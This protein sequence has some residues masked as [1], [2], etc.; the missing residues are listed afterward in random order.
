MECP[1]T[2]HAPERPVPEAG[3]AGAD[4]APTGGQGATRFRRGLSIA[5]VVGVVLVLVTGILWL[6][7]ATSGSTRLAQD[8]DAV[9]VAARQAGETV[10][11]VDKSDAAGTVARWEAV[12]TGS[13]LDEL[14]TSHDQYVQ[15]IGKLPA[16]A[17]GTVT[18]AAVAE[19][20]DRAGTARVLVG[21]DVTLDDGGKTPP[22]RQRVQME[23]TRTDDGWKV[24]KIDPVGGAAG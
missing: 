19:L 1:M 3:T 11:A 20:D 12:A 5:V 13:Q 15:M 18:D 6:V 2:T 8:R 17:H 9:L 14:Q 23:M 7:T 10:T 22:T 24:A 16:S 21:M 4:A